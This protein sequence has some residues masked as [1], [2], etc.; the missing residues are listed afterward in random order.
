M[1]IPE[2][3]SRAFLDVGSILGPWP[4]PPPGETERGESAVSQV[5]APQFHSW[6]IVVP[7][8]NERKTKPRF[9]SVLHR[10][11]SE[12][13]THRWRPMVVRSNV[14]RG[15]TSTYS[16]TRRTSKTSENASLE[17]VHWRAY[18][19][20]PAFI[21]RRLARIRSHA[22]KSRHRQRRAALRFTVYVAAVT[23]RRAYATRKRKATARGF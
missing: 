10:L 14:K 18:A 23:E 13:C 9:G 4:I 17:F 7:G 3:T 12:R 2:S 20:Q 16:E 19:R 22:R 1:F 15:V 5:A 8:A 11:A 6:C 21:H